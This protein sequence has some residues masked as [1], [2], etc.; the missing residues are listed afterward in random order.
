MPKVG[1]I[2]IPQ[3]TVTIKDFKNTENLEMFYHPNGEYL[4]VSN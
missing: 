4:A 3:R 1:F 2:S